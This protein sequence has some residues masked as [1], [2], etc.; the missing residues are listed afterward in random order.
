LLVVIAIIAILAG[1][2]LPALQRAR[3]AA[4]RT[5]CLNNLK[6]IGTGLALYSSDTYYGKY[7]YLGPMGGE[8]TGLYAGGDG[9]IGDNKIFECPSDGDINYAGGTDGFASD[10]EASY[11]CSYARSGDAIALSATPATYGWKYSYKPNVVVAGPD[12]G[13]DSANKENA[14]TTDA[15]NHQFEAFVFLFKD[16]HTVI[17]NNDPDD[18]AQA[19]GVKGAYEDEDDMFANNESGFTHDA[20]K[21]TYL[22]WCESLDE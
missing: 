21:H 5:K 6:Q 8:N 9:I 22:N 2:L 12:D 16:G 4:N 10:E 20:N 13:C 11:Y 17:Q 1:M 14:P 7:P 15:G 3:E 18:G 19:I